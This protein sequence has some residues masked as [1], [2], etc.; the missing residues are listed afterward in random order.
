MTKF[1]DKILLETETKYY[2]SQL[3]N[4]DFEFTKELFVKCLDTMKHI[5]L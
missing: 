3:K 1:N 5:M 2:Q 4:F